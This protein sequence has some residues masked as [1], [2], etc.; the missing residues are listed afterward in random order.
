M[1]DGGSGLTRLVERLCEAEGEEVRQAADRGTVV[2]TPLAL[3]VHSAGYVWDGHN[4][5]PWAMRTIASSSF[6]QLDIAKN[7]P[8]LM[9]DIPRLRKGN[10]GAQFWSVFVPASTR[11]DGTALQTTI[12]QIELVREMCRRYPDVFAFATTMAEV[13]AARE[14]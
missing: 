7:Q 14:Q 2:V 13:D 9:T 8:S 5:L 12:E 4:D 6:D 11:L 1:R 3:E 10:V